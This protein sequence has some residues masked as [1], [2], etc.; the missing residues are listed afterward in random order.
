[1]TG[2]RPFSDRWWTRLLIGPAV[3]AAA[4]A[5]DENLTAPGGCPEYCP[6]G[7]VI[8]VDTVFTSAIA[9]DS[10]FRGFVAARRATV[11]QVAAD[12]TTPSVALVRFFP[13]PTE[14]VTTDG[15]GPAASVDSLRLT[16]IVNARG[17]GGS[18]LVLR[19]HRVPVSVDSTTTFADLGPYLEDST[20]IGMG[21]VPDSVGDTLTIVLPGDAFPKLLTDDELVA[22]VAIALEAPEPSFVN[23]GTFESAQR[24]V[25]ERFV[26]VDV[27]ADT[28]PPGQDAQTVTFDT[29]VYEGLAEVGPGELAAGGTPSARSLIRVGLPPAVIDSAHIVRATLLLVPT[30]PLFG[31]PTDS[32]ELRADRLAADFGPKSPIVP[33]TLDSLRIGTA[34]VPTGWTDTIRIDITPLMR[35]WQ[36]QPSLPRAFM[37]RAAPEAA[38]MGELR[39]YSSEGA[40]PPGLHVTYI[41]LAQLV[42][43]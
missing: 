40:N 25:L 3:L 13:F 10:T 11:M 22:A 42:G 15:A 8:V 21:T 32:L 39:L 37:L 16:V 12:P 31:A 18:D 29:Y 1:M 5:C 26:Q 38:K 41:P 23:L 9:E 33:T 14:L 24:A 27:G 7:A 19:V 17:P 36:A 6:P 35:A 34:R 43:R 4:V 20:R 28:T 30:R 2:R